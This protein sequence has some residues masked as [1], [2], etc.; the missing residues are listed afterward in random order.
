MENVIITLEGEKLGQTVRQNEWKG[1]LSEYE[2]FTLKNGADF[3]G[4][5][6]QAI[7]KCPKGFKSVPTKNGAVVLKGVLK[8]VKFLA[9]TYEIELDNL[10]E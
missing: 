4:R 3:L 1:K 2:I 9:G 6:M 10:P 8:G 7:V 5:A